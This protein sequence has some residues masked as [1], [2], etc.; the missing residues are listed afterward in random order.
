MSVLQ[1]M[2]SNVITFFF[3]IRLLMMRGIIEG[4]DSSDTLALS[5]S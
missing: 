4:T 1:E 3:V 2:H 5:G